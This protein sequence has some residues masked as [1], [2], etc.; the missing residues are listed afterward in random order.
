MDAQSSVDFLLGYDETMVVLNNVLV[1][2]G[3]VVGEKRKQDPAAKVAYHTM[4]DKADS[5]GGFVLQ[6]KHKVC[7]AKKG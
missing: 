1:T 7:W 2:V 6:Q 5:A 3:W 4:E